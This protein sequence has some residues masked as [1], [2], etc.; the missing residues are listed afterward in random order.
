MEV[1]NM[2][3]MGP[4][5]PD[6]YGNKYVLTIIDSFTRAVGLY[7]VVEQT[8]KEAARM[9]TQHVGIF[10][11]PRRIVS[12]K[13]TQFTSD[14]I[15]EFMTILGTDHHLTL[16]GSKQEDSQAENAN[17]RAQEFLRSMLFDRRIVQRW[18][19]VLPLV[20]RIMMA[21][22]NEVTGISPAKLLF[23]NSIDLD[24][25]IF[26]TNLNEDEN[27]EVAISDWADRM[28]SSQKILLDIATRK[29]QLKDHNHLQQ[30]PAFTTEYE[31]GMYVLV[32]PDKAVG[33]GKPIGKFTPRN[34]GPYLIV[35]REND[36]YTCRNLID[37]DVTDFHVTR[38]IPYR[39]DVDFMDPREV[40]L[41]DKGDYDVE[42]V[43][44]HE[45]ASNSKSLK[46]LKFRVKWLGFDEAYNTWELWKNLR[47]TTA[48]HRYLIDNNMKA[49]VP[50]K[51]YENY[52]STFPRK[53]VVDSVYFSP[54]TP[55]LRSILRK[56]VVQDMERSHKKK[57]TKLHVRFCHMTE[58]DIPKSSSFSNKKRK[59]NKGV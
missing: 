31:I 39:H 15:K 7:A 43:I 21:E 46:T 48:L 29:Q 25:G 33:L 32:T 12:D 13:G 3:F 45:Y 18:S 56:R 6:D 53:V 41:R 47:E 40:A 16:V 26:L 59:L 52:P 22:P 50:K 49:L 4:F 42:K 20:Q 55:V 30:A 34:T 36:K 24:R 44:A 35:K 57:C 17:K 37:E 23:G 1:L 8:A 5:P 38:L 10:G 2:D 14:L 27:K 19:D 58:G 11:C 28:L 54:H 51:F 9:L